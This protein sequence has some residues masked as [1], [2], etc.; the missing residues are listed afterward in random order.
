MVKIKKRENRLHRRAITIEEMNIGDLINAYFDYSYSVDTSPWSKD[1]N[2]SGG[3]FYAV[4]IG[5]KCNSNIPGL[6]RLYFYVYAKNGS[7]MRY[8]YEDLIDGVSLLC[9]A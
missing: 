6:N 7:A 5:I 2:Y 3:Y 4:F 9:K 8:I 1:R